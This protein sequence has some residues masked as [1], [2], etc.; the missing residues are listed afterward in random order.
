VGVSVPGVTLLRGVTMSSFWQ[1][2][3]ARAKVAMATIKMF[4]FII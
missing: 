3:M 4:F 1:A 2:V